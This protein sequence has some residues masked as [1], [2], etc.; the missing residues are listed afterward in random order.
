MQTFLWL[1]IALIGLAYIW[2]KRRYTYWTRK[3]VTQAEGKFPFGSLQGVSTKLTIFERYDEIYRM[4][5]GKARFV[6]FY[7]FLAPK[8]LIL[9]PELLKQILT[10]NFASFNHSGMYYNKK[11][12]PLSAK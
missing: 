7:A 4:F 8:I 11:D 12:D 3:G 10:S 2:L 5:K 1:L 9:D 6:G